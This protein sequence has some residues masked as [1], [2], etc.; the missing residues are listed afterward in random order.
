MSLFLIYRI[1]ETERNYVLPY[2]LH[3][4][5]LEKKLVVSCIA[6]ECNLLRN[7][8]KVH[9][10]CVFVCLFLLHLVFCY[11]EGLV[12]LAAAWHPADTPCL[13]YYCLLMLPDRL[14]LTSDEIS[15]EVTKHNPAFQV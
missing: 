13:V 7:R 3:V 15:V 8:N 14:S 10:F 2:K 9:L 6:C 1:L 11:R 5:L 4:K 12:I